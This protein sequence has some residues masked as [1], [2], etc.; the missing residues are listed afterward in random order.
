VRRGAPKPTLDVTAPPLVTTEAGFASVLEELRG[1]EAYALDTEF[2][3]ER[4]YFPKLAL[5]QL[6]WDGGMALVDPLAVDIAPLAE[7]LRGPA[8]AVLHAASQDLEVLELACGTVPERLV[9]TQIAAGFV[10]MSTPSLSDLHERR[11][12]SALPKGDRLTDWLQRP[13]RPEQLRYAASDVA[14]L[15]PLWRDL[16][17]DLERRGRLAWA[18][19]ECALL[20]GRA[21]GGRRPEE[22]YLRV[23]EVRQLRGRGLAVAREVAAWRERRAATLDIPVR[24]VLSDLAVAGL[25]QRAPRGP[26]DLRGIR[27]LDERSLRPAVL[28]DLLEAVRRG[29][30]APP[31]ELPSTTGN[32]VDAE[33]RGAIGMLSSWVSQLGRDLDLDPALVATRNDLEDLLRQRPTGR[34]L[35]GWRADLVGR[36][37]GALLRGEASLVFDAGRLRL[38]ARAGR[39]F[40]APDDRGN[41]H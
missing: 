11:L 28:E 30:E 36:Q 17:A 13:L 38:E 19:D 33:F 21:R 22:A 18:L 31:P 1:V 23:K 15:L 25:A 7:V 4:T 32:A 40:G 2:H 10:G 6:A 35:E 5:L 37:V 9:D 20:L 8:V 41:E 16:A 24:H 26:E 34:L 39:P 14:D 29:S 3:R 12:G 27:G